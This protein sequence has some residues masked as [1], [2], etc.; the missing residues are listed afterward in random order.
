MIYPFISENWGV[1]DMEKILLFLIHMSFT[2]LSDG[3]SG[4]ESVT[5]FYV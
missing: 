2:F 1:E 4:C 5:V 3:N